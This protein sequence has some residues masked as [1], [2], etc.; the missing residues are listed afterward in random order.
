MSETRRT[1]EERSA[2]TRAKLLDAT[3]TCLI[4]RGYGGTTTTE[5]AK[6]AGVSR[7]AQL[8]HFPVKAELMGAAVEHVFVRRQEEFTEAFLALPAESDKVSAAIDLLWKNLQGGIFYAWLE[9]VVASRSDPELRERLLSV[10]IKFDQ[11]IQ[12]LVRELF[13]PPEE[14]SELLHS[15]GHLLFAAMEG[16]STSQIVYGSRRPCGEILDVLKTMIQQAVMPFL[17][18]SL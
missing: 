5:I 9:L 16:L 8:H 6:V 12:S 17:Q 11:D 3:V 18:R 13:S 1:N 14:I 15:T 2:T 4:E 10:C 7:G